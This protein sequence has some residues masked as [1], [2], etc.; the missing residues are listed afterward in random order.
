LKTITSD[1]YPFL[2]DYM[3]L[4]NAYPSK[5]PDNLHPPEFLGGF[6]VVSGFPEIVVDS[7][8]VNMLFPGMLFYPNHQT[9]VGVDWF[10]RSNDAVTLYTYNSSTT[11][12][13]ITPDSIGSEDSPVTANTATPV[14]CTVQP[15]KTPVMAVYRVENKT[16]GV[17]GQILYFTPQSI[18]VSYP[19]GEPWATGDTLEVDYRYNPVSQ[20]HLKPV[21]MRYENQPRT[22]HTIIINGIPVTYETVSLGY[23]TSLFTFP[24]FYI[25]NDN[26][27]VN[28]IAREMLNW[29][30]YPTLHP[31]IQ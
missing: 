4:L 23:R 7:N 29:F 21:A 24:L 17:V 10:T 18:V 9:L 11:N 22:L 1:N 30:F 2:Y 3:Q 19:Y 6:P 5:Y 26:G 20:N 25:K 16:K 27:Q 31:S 28:Q 8:H 14:Q 15:V 13:T 12:T